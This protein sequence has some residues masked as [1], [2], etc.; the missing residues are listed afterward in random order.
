MANKLNLFQEL[1]RRG[2]KNILLDTIFNLEKN[3]NVHSFLQC[4]YLLSDIYYQ[5]VFL[6]QKDSYLKHFLEGVVCIISYRISRT[7]RCLQF[8]KF[9]YQIEDLKIKLIKLVNYKVPRL[10]SCGNCNDC[11]S[12]NVD[13]PNCIEWIFSS[14][15]L[16]FQTFTK[17]VFYMVH[18]V[19]KITGGIHEQWEKFRCDYRNYKSLFCFK[20]FLINRN[21]EFALDIKEKVIF[22]SDASDYLHALSHSKEFFFLNEVV[23]DCVCGYPYHLS[24]SNIFVSHEQI[25]YSIYEFIFG[26]S[27]SRYLRPEEE[28]NC[29]V[30][31]KT[32]FKVL[33]IFKNICESGI[34]PDVHRKIQHHE[35]FQIISMDL[36]QQDYLFERVPRNHANEMNMFSFEKLLS[37]YYFP[38]PMNYW[39]RFVDNNR[40]LICKKNISPGRNLSAFQVNEVPIRLQMH[41]SEQDGIISRNKWNHFVIE[42][43]FKS[44][45]DIDGSTLVHF[46]Q[47]SLR[48]SRFPKFNSF[49]FIHLPEQKIFRFLKKCI[50]KRKK[51]RN[52][53]R[54]LIIRLGESY[55]IPLDNILD[56]FCYI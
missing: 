51:I 4:N 27:T 36:F 53:K 46:F 6:L 9:D 42:D 12:V 48:G 22:S 38:D 54:L 39:K 18:N 34:F 45:F 55:R 1:K 28:I 40:I 37:P 41:P 16:P 19:N 49:L 47:T 44:K 23:T 52:L 3:K 29:F 10:P 35:N 13:I 50:Q 31:K 14:S 25:K 7:R 33:S 56:I 8:S 11:I 17:D 30:T 32:F 43:N 15:E 24:N 2:R 26:I 5:D 20:R 21:L